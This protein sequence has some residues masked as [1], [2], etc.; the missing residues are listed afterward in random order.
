MIPSVLSVEELIN[1]ARPASKTASPKWG[2]PLNRAWSAMNRRAML[3]TCGSAGKGER[4]GCTF[5]V[6]ES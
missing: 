1:I 4:K 6:I 5:P 3:E 2:G